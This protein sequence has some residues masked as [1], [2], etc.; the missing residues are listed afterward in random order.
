MGQRLEPEAGN[1]IG[2]DYSASGMRRKTAGACASCI[3]RDAKPDMQESLTVYW[4]PQGSRPLAQ[5]DCLGTLKIS[6]LKTLLLYPFL[7]GL[8]MRLEACSSVLS[9]PPLPERWGGTDSLYSFTACPN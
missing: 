8:R 9:L 1:R 4:G 2:T 7:G 5:C 3:C 6:G